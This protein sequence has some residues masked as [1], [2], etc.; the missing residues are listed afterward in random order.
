MTM[1]ILLFFLGLEGQTSSQLSV[2]ER[3]K[4][5]IVILLFFL[6]V[7]KACLFFSRRYAM[8]LGLEGQTSSLEDMQ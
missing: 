8:T 1:V 2:E 6:G 5:T 4:L 7:G 3:T